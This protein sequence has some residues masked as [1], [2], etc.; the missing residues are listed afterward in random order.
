MRSPKKEWLP[1]RLVYTIWLVVLTVVKNDGA[2][3]W[4]GWHPIYDGKHVPNHQTAIR[5]EMILD[6]PSSY[7]NRFSVLRFAKQLPWLSPSAQS[8][9][10][11]SDAEADGSAQ[12][13][14]ARIDRGTS[15]HP[16]HG[17]PCE[18]HHGWA[19]W[20]LRR[21]ICDFGGAQ[22]GI[23]IDLGIYDSLWT[24]TS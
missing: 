19:K 2:R 22:I 15:R 20:R 16:C 3:Q 23:S 1:K 12:H 14:W 7:Q 13:T 24:T 21:K 17:T 10:K 6:F 4:E 8:T 9:R 5:F 18:N 11:G